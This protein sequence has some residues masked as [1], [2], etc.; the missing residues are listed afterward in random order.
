MRSFTD[1]DKAERNS[2]YFGYGVHKVQLMEFTNGGT[3]DGEKEYIEVSF[4]DPDD[5]EKIDNARVWFTTD[6][7]AQYSF[8]TLRNIYVHNAPDAKKDAARADFDKL[9]NTDEICTE[10]NDKLIGK[11]AWFTKY[12]D[13]K[14]TYTGKDGVVRKSINKNVLGYEPK[15]N[16]ALMPKETPAGG[17]ANFPGAEE[18]SEDAKANVPSS[19]D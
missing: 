4:C 19:W 13:P 5:G 11:E 8:S 17:D 10:M 3:G 16:D 6:A 14:R 15:V 12:Q 7:A 1:D 18:A 9:A 2:N